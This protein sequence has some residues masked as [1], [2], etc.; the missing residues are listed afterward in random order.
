LKIDLFYKLGNEEQKKVN[1]A[2]HY[3]INNIQV[4]L[5]LKTKDLILKVM[6]KTKIRELI[7]VYQK[8]K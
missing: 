3:L 6:T 2:I 1:S 5:L 7:V 8:K 4:L